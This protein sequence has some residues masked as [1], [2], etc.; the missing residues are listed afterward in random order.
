MSENQG[1]HE[2]GQIAE[3]VEQ[4]QP[5]ATRLCTVCGERPTISD[6]CPYCPSCM[7]KKGLEKKRLKKQNGPV[8]RRRKKMQEDLGSTEEATVKRNTAVTIDFEK[9]PTLL[10]QLQDLAEREIRPLDL[11]MI[12]ILKGHID[13][14][15]VAAREE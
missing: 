1:R 2:E 8:R 5:A 12:Y 13:A 7:G 6:S 10:Q 15:H 14:L 11:Q 9:Y 3:A 4:K